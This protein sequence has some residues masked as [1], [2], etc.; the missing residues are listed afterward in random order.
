MP[1]GRK[2]KTEETIIESQV[3]EGVTTEN[4]VV[5]EAVAT[6]KPKTKK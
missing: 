1:R 4:E 3:E 2:K 5:E 6:E